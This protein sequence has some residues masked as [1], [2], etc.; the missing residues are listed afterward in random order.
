MSLGDDTHHNNKQ[1]YIAALASGL[2]QPGDLELVVAS[3]ILGIN[4]VVHHVDG[5]KIAY[6]DDM[7]FPK[8]TQV[9]YYPGHYNY[10]I[11]EEV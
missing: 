3:D 5:H 8:T 6:P 1:A 10:L 7:H 9:K 11:G 4:I 2:L